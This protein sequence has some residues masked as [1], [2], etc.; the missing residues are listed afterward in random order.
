MV[1]SKGE[2]FDVPINTQTDLRGDALRLAFIAGED[3]PLD[4]AS[5]SAL[6]KVGLSDA[7]IAKHFA[8]NHADVRALR[9]RYGISGLRQQNL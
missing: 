6:V 3:W 2:I 5:L 9:T 7:R 4:P 1:V 8:V